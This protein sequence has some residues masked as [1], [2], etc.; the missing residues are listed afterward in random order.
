MNDKNAFKALKKFVPKKLDIFKENNKSIVEYIKQ[1]NDDI[2]EESLRDVDMVTSEFEDAYED[3][4]SKW[5]KKYTVDGGSS[6][7][8]YQPTIAD[9]LNHDEELQ[10]VGNTIQQKNWAIKN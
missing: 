5:I 9:Y 6:V 2:N 10:T 1:S 7:F 3:A 8:G 4:V